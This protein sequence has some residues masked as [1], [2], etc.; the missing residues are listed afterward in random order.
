MSF[1][2]I[3]ILTN[4]VRYWGLVLTILDRFLLN[5]FH[6]L[7]N[8]AVNFPA[9]LQKESKKSSLLVKIALLAII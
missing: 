6:K 8:W 7:I 3:Q 2:R 9:F 5:I 4:S 1:L